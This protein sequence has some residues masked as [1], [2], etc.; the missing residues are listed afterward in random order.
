MSAGQWTHPQEGQK[1]LAENQHVLGSCETWLIAVEKSEHLVRA[2]TR[3]P[4][5]KK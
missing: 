5:V 1:F 3:S 4:S 2:S